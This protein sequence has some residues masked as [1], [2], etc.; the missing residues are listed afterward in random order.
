M[1]YAAPTMSRD[2]E[3]MEDYVKGGHHPVNI[4]ETFSHGR[5]IV[6]DKLGEG[7]SFSTEWLAKDYEYVPCLLISVIHNL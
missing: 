7:D 6:L 1:P 3:D 5:Y 4:G 2:E